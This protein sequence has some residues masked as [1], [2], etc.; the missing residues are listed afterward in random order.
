MI[1]DPA[2]GGVCSCRMTCAAAA[3]ISDA[4]SG[5]QPTPVIA[6]SCRDTS[7]SRPSDN[8]RTH[9]S[10]DPPAPRRSLIRFEADAVTARTN[11]TRVL[12]GDA[13][14]PDSGAGVVQT[15]AAALPSIGTRQRSPSFAVISARPSALQNA[16]A[17]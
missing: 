17:S 15:G 6:P 8:V 13:T 12:S 2:Y 5:D 16:P 3:K 1:F 4:P 9:S 14:I 11:A 7:V 10:A